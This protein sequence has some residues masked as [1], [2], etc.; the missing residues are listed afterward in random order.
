MIRLIAVFVLLGT[1]ALWAE[2]EGMM[3]PALHAVVGVAETDVLNIRAAPDPEAEVVG[4]LA[5]NQMG[6]EVIRVTEGWAEVNTGEVTGFAALRFLEREEGPDW[7]ALARPLACFGTEPFWSLN[8]DPGAS[9]ATFITPDMT[10]ARTD[11]IG[12]TWP[13]TLWAP[14]AA[15]DLP[16]GLAVLSPGD[17]SDGMSE[18]S[19]GIAVD[20]F[21]RTGD[22]QRISGCCT[23]ALR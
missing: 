21:L 1:G 8:L 3:F 2:V 12:Q 23:L 17:C 4:T 22:R 7:Y 6:V 16:D 10:E 19:Y 9:T 13:G 14:R 5:P 15:I 11:P 20:L 18:Q